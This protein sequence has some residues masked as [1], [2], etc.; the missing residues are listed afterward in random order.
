MIHRF[1]IYFYWIFW[2][3]LQDCD[4]EI[5]G[6]E[7]MDYSEVVPY[8]HQAFLADWRPHTSTLTYPECISTTSREGNVAHNAFS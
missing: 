4:A 8:V 1:W 3:L 7:C 5:A 2:N 6:S